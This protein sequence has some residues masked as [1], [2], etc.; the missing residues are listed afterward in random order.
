MKGLVTSTVAALAVGATNQAIADRTPAS[1]QTRNNYIV[2]GSAIALGLAGQLWG[3]NG[4][5]LRASNGLLNGGAAVI[6]A[7]LTVWVDSKMP[8]AAAPA[9]PAAPAANLVRVQQVAASPVYGGQ[10]L[11]DSFDSVGL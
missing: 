3:R 9:A 11:G 5:T 7:P 6:A 10:N 2:S 1:V 8:K 4:F